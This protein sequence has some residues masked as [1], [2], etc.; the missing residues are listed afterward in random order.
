M[1]SR[2]RRR[3]TGLQCLRSQR[4]NQTIKVHLPTFIKVT[5]SLICIGSMLFLIGG[6]TSRKGV[7]SREQWCMCLTGILG[8]L[9]VGLNLYWHFYVR[10]LQFR[11]PAVGYYFAWHL[12]GGIALGM[13]LYVGFPKGAKL[14]LIGSAILLVALNL[15]VIVRHLG[16]ATLFFCMGNSL[17]IGV[18]IPSAAV[19]WLNHHEKNH[20]SGNA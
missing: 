1:V 17:V 3:R 10:F 16:T 18:L 20:Q 12:V 2:L 5:L 19:F 14:L 6:L 11:A 9:Y 13:F 15:F 4:L 8:L 7:R